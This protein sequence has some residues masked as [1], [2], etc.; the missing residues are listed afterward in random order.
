MYWR[1]VDTEFTIHLGDLGYFSKLRQ[2]RYFRRV[3][4]YRSTC[5]SRFCDKQKNSPKPNPS[6]F[7]L[8]SSSSK[9]SHTQALTNVSLFPWLRLSYIKWLDKNQTY[10]S[11]GGWMVIYHRRLRKNMTLNKHKLVMFR[12]L[13]PNHSREKPITSTTAGS[14]ESPRQQPWTWDD[15]KGIDKP[16]QQKTTSGIGILPVIEVHI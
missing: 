2:G 3:S 16:S 14:G 10:S 5:F 1:V 13:S 6:F 12:F 11:A 15:P 9:L 4:L 8:P 7:L